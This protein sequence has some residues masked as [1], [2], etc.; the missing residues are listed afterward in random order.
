[1]NNFEKVV[2]TNSMKKFVCTLFLLLF[3]NSAAFSYAIKIYD[4]YGNRIGTYRKEGEQFVLYDFNDKKV[5]N[6]EDLL[7]DPP[8]QKV[9]TQYTQY[10]YDENMVPIGSFSSGI[11]GPNGYY[12]PKQGYYYPQSWQRTNAPKIVCPVKNYSFNFYNQTKASPTSTYIEDVRYP[13]F[14]DFKK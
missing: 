4:E 1:M 6:P 9:L 5:E 12:Y 14:H 7:K 3:V 2:V 10:F 11:Y 8:S 13:K